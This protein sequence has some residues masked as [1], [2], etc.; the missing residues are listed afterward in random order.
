MNVRL[1]STTYMTLIDPVGLF[2]VSYNRGVVIYYVL[3]T[4]I[5]K[6]PNK[7]M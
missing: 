4:S 2:D 1:F 5:L 6:R 3:N 7:T